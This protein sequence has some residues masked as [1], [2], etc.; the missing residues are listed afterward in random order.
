[1]ALIRHV[2]DLLADFGIDSKII[3]DATGAKANLFATIGPETGGGI[4]LSGHTDVVPTDGQ[5]WSVPPFELTEAN[6]RLFGRGTTDMKGFV[7]CAINAASKA[8]QRSL[9]SPLH[10]AL[11]YDEEV[12]CLGVRDLIK[13]VQDAEIQPKFCIV[14][15]PTSLTV[16][17]GHKGK[18][19]YR[20]RFSGKEAHSALAPTGVN[21]IHMATDFITAIRS[22]Q[23]TIADHGP[24]DG[25]Y[26]IAYTTLHVGKFKGG[27][28]LN[29]VPSQSEIEFEIR[30]LADD[31]PE[32]IF[33]ALVR[34]AEDITDRAREIADDADIRFETTIE[35]PGLDT[36]PDS[37]IVEFVKGLTGGNAT[38]KVA[39]G[40]EGGLFNQRLGLPVIICGPGSMEQG[41][42]PDEFI[43]REQ[44]DRCD[45]MLNA[46]IDRL[47]AGI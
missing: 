25:D 5:D 41:H 47:E 38:I 21:A 44:M 17:T 27:I 34:S 15:E 24:R 12:G 22:E 23:A 3:P 8:S 6:G 16:A 32:K 9:E 39:Y 36:A 20:V 46:L 7:A 26:D 35:Y 40:T 43:S 13:F 42:K 45:Q 30:H 2:A 28:A 14:G 1:M 10:L 33:A 31:D 19:G 37:E 11:S 4:I 29:I 18:I